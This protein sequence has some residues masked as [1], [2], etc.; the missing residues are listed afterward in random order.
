VNS[1]P[2][3][4]PIGNKTV[5][6]LTLLTF[7]A[8]AYD[9]DG[10][11][12]TFSLDSSAPPGASI[13]EAGIFTWTPTEEQGPGTYTIR[14]IVSDANLID[15]EDITITV[16][17][18]NSAPV[19]DP[20]GPKSINELELLTFNATATD[21]DIPV[22]TLTFSIGK[23]APD[24]ASI[25][26]T[27]IFTWTPTEEQGP[28]NYTI[29]V[30]VSDGLL[31][32]YEDVS[33]TIYEIHIH[34]IAIINVVASP[35]DVIS[36]QVVNIV[37]TVKNQGTV[38]ETFNVTVFCNENFIETR[39][40]TNLAPG[41][42]RLLEFAWNTR[43][44]TEASYAIRAEA[45]TV[46]GEINLNNNRYTG[47][48]IKVNAQ[49]SF[50]TF[51]TFDWITALSYALPLILSLIFLT[52]LKLKSKKKT[53][54]STEKKTEAFSQ[55]FGMT[56]KQMIGKKMLLEIDPTL[57]YY[58]VLSSFISEAK[59]SG[60]PL[61]ILTNKNSTLHST[62]SG[63]PDVKFLLLTSKT[64]SPQ[65]INNKETLLPASDLSVLLEAFIRIQKVKTKK[66]INILI[67]NLSD[68]I[69]R[70]GFEKT[71][72]FTRYLLEAIS[73]PKITALFLFNPRAHE[74]VVSSS[75]RGLFR[76][77]LAY[78]KSGPKVGT[79]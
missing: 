22:Q 36:G 37:V 74:T 32:D 73:S 51:K 70:C 64:S 30:I 76:D 17:E 34:D 57:D 26:D 28:G 27:G 63:D 60:E 4:D 54:P 72:K 14:I 62:F 29:R 45:S 55:L 58:R 12:L 71:Y 16:N 2:V 9:S 50:Q 43:G 59:N 8:T 18:V 19:L 48:S 6:E 33:V 25:T 75:I 23:G 39:T 21:S 1:P 40:V 68:I 69:L 15:Y 42:Q 47:N 49:T 66:N 67:D 20:I 77:Q 65:H 5:N 11:P 13:S 56:H 3:L 44:V 46:S 41:D 38:T 52:V 35:T 10:D 53:K 79:L 7:N 78:T 31:F 61:F 24:G